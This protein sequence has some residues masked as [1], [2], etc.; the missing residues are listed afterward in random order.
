MA[1]TTKK[2][3]A[4]VQIEGSFF[5][6]LWAFYSTNRSQIRKSYKEP[7]KRVLDH[8]DP[9]KR[10]QAYLRRPQ[11]EALEIYVFLKE[12][13][14]NIRV[15]ELFD[16]WYHKEQGFEQRGGLGL[17]TDAQL[18]MLPVGEAF[19]ETAYRALY[20]QMKAA[21]EGSAH[22]ATIAP[23]YIFALTMGT[24]KTILMATCILYEFLLAKTFPDDP[25]FAHNALVFAPDTTVLESLREIETFDH[26]LVLPQEYAKKLC[27][28]LKFHVLADAQTSLAALEH[29]SFNVVISNTQKIILKRQRRA[30]S[31]SE[32]L[33]GSGKPTY[34]ST[35]AW[36]KAAELYEFDALD[37]EDALITNQRFQKLCRLKQLSIYIDEAHHAFGSK[38]A[39]DLGQDPKKETS[40]HLTVRELISELAK[41]STRV[42]AT[43]CYTGTPYADGVL[44]PEVVYAYGLKE[45]IDSGLLKQLSVTT[46]KNTE[47][48]SSEFVRLV[49]DHFL[50]HVKQERY[51]GMRPKL[52]IFASEIEEV[53][54]DLRPAVEQSLRRHN[55]PESRILV[56]VGDSKYTTDDDIR[57]FNRLD[58]AASDK[59][60]ILLV[61]K[62]KEG[63]NCRSLFGVALYRKPKSRIFVLQ[64]TMRCLRAIEAPVQHIGHVFVSEE[65]RDIL[66]DELRQ[67]FRV[68]LDDMSASGTKKNTVKI[69]LLPPP[70]QITLRRIRHKWDLTNKHPGSG[71]AFCFDKVDVDPYKLVRE[72]EQR[73]L[74]AGGRRT[75][76]VVTDITHLRDQRKFTALSITAECARYLN[77]SPLEI[78]KVLARSQEGIDE[79]L[80]WVNRYNGLLYGHV[81]PKLFTAFYDLTTNKVQEEIIVNLVKEPEEGFYTVTAEPDKVVEPMTPEVRGYASKSF[82][83]DHYCFDSNP[84]KRLFFDLIRHGKVKQIYFTGM[85]THGQSDFFIDY[86]DPESHTVRSYYPDFV[87][88][89]TD[90]EWIIVEVKGDDHINDP[91]VAAKKE[92]T[93]QA[94]GQMRYAII[95]GSWVNQGRSAEVLTEAGSASEPARSLV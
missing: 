49:I 90:N 84:E 4:E 72:E 86:I 33:F 17:S 59:Q 92:Y 1:K 80:S 79:I 47:P 64:A 58:S 70:R 20:N 7:T 61:N 10:A 34:Q 85:L 68:S 41:N 8:N 37:N 65:N 2:T 44:F 26:S 81:V 42:I 75:A 14:G 21:A 25:R 35:G 83:L 67:N 5:R 78:E 6:Y 39:Q 31:A 95:A 38:L 40:F 63:W 23:N 76:A 19:N 91:I 62:G 66:D 46:F 32:Q 16:R 55:I 93:E 74:A 88:Q 22:T 3:S 48:K 28:L 9:Q 29:S 15:F 56:N 52:A 18:T 11:F 13:A 89:T 24:G 43:Y 36:A 12:Y 57:E 69:K 51:D 54:N 45:A 82:H 60:F 71:V 30:P 94:A 53:I 73:A 27:P 87:V 77:R 50:E